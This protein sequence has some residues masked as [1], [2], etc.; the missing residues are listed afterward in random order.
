MCRQN[1]KCLLLSLFI[2]LYL[3]SFEHALVEAELADDTPKLLPTVVIATLVRNKAHTLPW[4]LGLIEKLD[5]PKSRI[6][7]W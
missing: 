5:Y 3:N 6:A 7:L 1:I 4:F 2:L